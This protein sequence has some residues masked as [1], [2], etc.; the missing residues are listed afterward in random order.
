M[1]LL[2][3]QYVVISAVAISV[4]LVLRGWRRFDRANGL[5]EF[6]S[7]RGL[8]EFAWVQRIVIGSGRRIRF[9]DPWER[10]F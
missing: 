3:I 6:D 9:G 8:H 7:F 4:I 5:R 10:K 1:Y 2:S